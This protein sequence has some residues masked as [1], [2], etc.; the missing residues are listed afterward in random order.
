MKGKG[1]ERKNVG[2]GKGMKVKTYERETYER[3]M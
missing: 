2:K 1:Y 3:K